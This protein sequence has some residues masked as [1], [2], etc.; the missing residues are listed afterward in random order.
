MTAYVYWIRGEKFAELARLSIASVRKVDPKADVY[1]WTDDYRGTPRFDGVA[2]HVL[3]PG[4]PAMVANLD[5][6]LAALN[7]LTRGT[8][9]LFL[10]ADTILRRP[11]PFRLDADLY[12]TWRPDVNGDVEMAKFQ[13]YNYGVLGTHV[14]PVTIEAFLWLRAR[15]LQMTPKNQGWYGNQLAL[16]DL[17]GGPPAEGEASKECRIHWAM[18]DRGTPLKVKQLPCSVWNYSPN[19]LGEDVSE[20]AILHLKGDRKDLMQHYAEA[21]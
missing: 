9:V 17:V 8:Q 19:E 13:P 6:Q 16:A 10:D 7:Y 14:R 5:A 12:V 20:R 2:W 1:V 21:A 15:I 4:R 18:N 11:F 3:E